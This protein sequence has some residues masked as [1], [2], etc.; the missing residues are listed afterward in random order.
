MF[1]KYT[2]I[3]MIVEIEQNTKIKYEYDIIMNKIRCDRILNIPL[4]YPGNYGFIPNTLSLDKDPLDIILINTCNL[5][6]NIVI[7]VKIIG[8]LITEDE[9]GEDEKII[10]VP[11]NHVDPINKHINDI[12]DVNSNILNNIKYFFTHYKD[13]DINKWVKVGDLKNKKEA[14]KIISLCYDRFKK[15]NTNINK[16]QI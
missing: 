5:L 13:N 8:V 7:N 9:H 1:N 12:S 11:S 15:Q 10:A 4:V 14:L 6:P 3:D 2:N 16:I